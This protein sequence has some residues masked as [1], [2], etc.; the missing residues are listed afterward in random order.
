MTQAMTFKTA[1]GA[2]AARHIEDPQWVAEQKLDGVRCMVQ[3]KNGSVRLLNRKGALLGASSSKIRE[4]IEREFD[5][6][7][8]FGHW[9]FDGEL[10]PDG[11]LWLFDLIEAP[12]S[13]TSSQEFR[14]RRTALETFAGLVGWDEGD[15][16]VRIVPQA[17]GT[18][19]KQAL[20]DAVSAGGGEG[21]MLKNLAAM[22]T[23][24]RTET[25][26]VK[27]KFVKDVDCVVMD[28]GTYG[29]DNRMLG[30]FCDGNLV[31]VGHCSSIGKQHADVGDVVE[32]R[33][34]YVTNR[35]KLY[36]PR[37]MRVRYD[38]APEECT[39]DQIESLRTSRVVVTP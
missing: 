9:L 17:E 1:L 24:Y 32:V 11:T 13:V 25:A 30:L 18:K 22:Y 3:I 19:A 39:F 16:L 28:N 5:A 27:V 12:G 20:M 2:T 15:G 7:S 38:K 34:L 29:K 33:C 4:A 23:S 6:L 10:M 36:Q 21:I 14:H 35:D 8:L 26:G 31:V 37:Q